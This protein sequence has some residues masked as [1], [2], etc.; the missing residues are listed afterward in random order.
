MSSAGPRDAPRSPRQ[1]AARAREPA[2]VHWRRTLLA[3]AALL[4]AYA[5]LHVVLQDISWWFVGARSPPLVLARRGRH[6]RTSCGSAGSPPLVGDR[7]SPCSAS[8]RVRGRHRVPRAVPDVRDAATASTRCINAG[9]T[10]S[11]SSASPPQPDAGIVLLL[12]LLDDRLRAVRRRRDR[13]RRRRPALVAAPAADAARHP[14]RGAR[15]HRRP[16]LVRGHRRVL[17][18]AILRIGRRPTTGAGAGARRRRRAR[19]RAADADVPA[20][21]DRGPGSARRRRADRHQPAD[22]PRRRPAP[23][24]RRWSP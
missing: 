22:Q 12:S 14:G 18:L 1:P 20:Q 2:R 21:V 8:P 13:D 4:A 11:R 17:F 3:L 19:R 23:R 10:R 7:R 16:A 6:P 24:R 15:R 5:G 9:W